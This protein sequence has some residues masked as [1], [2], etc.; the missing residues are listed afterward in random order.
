MGIMKAPY[1]IANMFKKMTGKGSK[2]APRSTADP[3]AAP[4]AVPL[5]GSH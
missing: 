5:G 2:A 3:Q 1:V 4:R